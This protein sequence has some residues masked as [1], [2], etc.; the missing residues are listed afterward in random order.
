MTGK[1]IRNSETKAEALQLQSSAQGVTI[2]WVRGVTRISGNL[3][4]YGGFKPNAHTETQGGKGGQRVKTTT[5]TYSASLYMGLCHGPLIDIPRVWRG[6]KIFGVEP[7]GSNIATAS[8]TYAVPASGA[9]VCTPPNSPVVAVIGV[10]S[11]S[12]QR[13]VEGV[14]YRAAAPTIFS[15][16]MVINVLDSSLRGT[17]ISYSYQYTTT[18]ISRTGLSAIG[19]SFRSGWYKPP[20]WSGLTAYPDEQVSYN[21]LGAVAG[22][23]YSLGDSA[24]VENHMFEVVAPM[25]YHLGAST[26]DVDPA[27]FVAELLLDQTAGASFPPQYLGDFQ[28]WS[29]YCVAAGLLISPALTETTTAADVIKTAADLTCSAISTSSGKLQIIPRADSAESDNGR[30]YTPNLT[31]VFDLTDES[32]APVSDGGSPVKFRDKENG[33]RYNSMSLQY[34][35]RNKNYNQAIASDVDAADVAARGLK[36]APSAVQA[37]WICKGAVAARVV[38]LMLQRSVSV[39]A[40]YD[41]PL[42]VHYSLLDLCDLV[43]VTDTKLGMSAEPLFV[44]GI[45]E[46]EDGGFTFQT[47]TYPIGAAGAATYKAPTAAGFNSDWNATPGSVETPIIFEAP[48]ALTTT[49][50]EVYI[51]ATGLSA[52]WGGCHVW[53]SNDG[54]NYKQIGDLQQP[55]RLGVLTSAIGSTVG[56]TLSRGTLTSGT[57]ADSAR[58]STLCYV[59]GSSPEYFAFADATLTGALAYTLGGLTRGGYGTSA[60]AHASGDPFVRLDEFVA[61][62][63]PLDLSMIGKT[64]YVKLTSYNIFGAAEQSLADVPAYTYTISGA[65]VKLPPQPPVSPSY[66]VEGYGIR[67]KCGTSPDPDVVRYEWRVGAS[68]DAATVLTKDGGTGYLWAAQIAG[69]YTAWVACVDV[70]GNYSTPVSVAVTVAAAT[71]SITAANFVGPDL[72]L[73]WVGTP[74]ALA[75]AGYELRYG[76]VLASATSIG[77]VLITRSVRRVDWSGARKWWVI[78]IDVAG[79]PGTAASIDV[80]VAVPGGV[81]ASRSEVVDNNALLYWGAPATG[82]LPVDRYEVRKGATWAGGSQV[83]SNGNSTF[84]A[85]FEQQAGTYTYWVTAYDTAGNAG[86]PVGIVA[87]INQPPDYVLRT[88]INSTFGG[89]ATNLTPNAGGLLGPVS[90]TET[91]AQHFSTRSWASPQDQINAGYPLY[92][93][94]GLASATYVESFDYGAVLPSTTITANLGTV[95]VAGTVNVSCQIAYKAAAGDAWTNAA[96]GATSVLATGFRYVQVTWTLSC[97]AGANLLQITSFNLKLSQKLRNDSGTVASVAAGGTA[98]TFGYPFIAADTPVFQ[99]AGST[100]LI[101]VVI[102]SGGAYPTGFTVRLYNLSGVDVGSASGGSWTVRGY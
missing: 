51:A 85:V 28:R 59:G 96:A 49:G 68:W 69:G 60:A 73:D 11:A 97:T 27:L 81:T 58:L 21:L 8:S 88:N 37:D 65:M 86:T 50:L 6:K 15:P 101:P 12:G 54:T 72:V 82:S 63:G 33:T 62:S 35:D 56:V 44:I 79:N 74:A 16:S 46:D 95:A 43:T 20:L 22:Q 30:T 98:I 17:T 70:F 99:P 25:A 61:K 78:P 57:A 38:K 64:L 9:M 100:P 102:Y 48:A 80:T 4:W 1:T 41:L 34:R 14:H 67:L 47:E 87:T 77:T 10:K 91:W 39:V 18:T 66:S 5:Y 71:V 75:I 84:A 89:T 76:A 40:E 31:P 83:G 53:V 13:L 36:A 2:P 90:T 32:F 93:E 19:L 92:A 29:D 7:I 42:P 24:S 55:S 45:D 94:P 3:I 23:D 52:N 26:P